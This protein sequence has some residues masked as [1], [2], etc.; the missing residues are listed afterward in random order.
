MSAL[1]TVDQLRPKG[2]QVI[3]N[4]TLAQRRETGPFVVVEYM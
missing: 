2:G 3:V 1:P 4:P